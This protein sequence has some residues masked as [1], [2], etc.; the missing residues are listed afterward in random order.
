M[1]QHY[2]ALDWSQKTMAFARLTQGSS[3]MDLQEHPTDLKGFQL[4]VSRLKGR[5]ILVVE[6]THTAQWLYT[7]L[8]S[9]VDEIVVCDPGRNRLLSEGPKTDKIDARKLVLLL[10]GNLLKPVFHSG[11]DFIRFRKLVSGYEDVVRMGVR[12]KNQRNALFRSQGISPRKEG[13]PDEIDQ[14]VLGGLDAHIERYESEKERYEKAFHRLTQKHRCLQHLKSIPGIGEIGALKLAA[15]IV[16]PHRFSSRGALWSYSGLI[17]HQK[18]S[19]GRTYGSRSPRYCRMLKSVF[20]TAAMSILTHPTAN[21]LR[22]YYL[23]LITEKKYAEFQARHALARR[24]ATIALGVMKSNRPY[25]P[26]RKEEP[27]SSTVF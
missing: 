8:R 16:D 14:F 27:L 7:E 18:L 11:D 19:G 26:H 25:E 24:V 10:R 5:K 13:L 9:Y 22:D 4:Y 12:L 21:P 15:R 3:Q 20:K 2:I 23:H 17:R 6:E 1:F